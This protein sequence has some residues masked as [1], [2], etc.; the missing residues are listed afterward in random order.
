[1]S[2]LLHT[3]RSTIL[4]IHLNRLNNLATS[5]F[6]EKIIFSPENCRKSTVIQDVVRN[7]ALN[8]HHRWCPRSARLCDLW[9]SSA[10]DRQCEFLC[11]SK[12]LCNL[13]HNTKHEH[14]TYCKQIAKFRLISGISPQHW[15]V[16]WAFDVPK[17]HASQRRKSLPV[18]GEN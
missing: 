11:F 3:S 2:T 17:R 15:R 8:G 6:C 1:M 7:A 10:L 9:N 5:R 13:Q 14:H 16:L 12:F 4:N 18:E